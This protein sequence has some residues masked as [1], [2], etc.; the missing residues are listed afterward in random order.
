MQITVQDNLALKV[1]D[2]DVKKLNLIIKNVKF[3][4]S[5]SL[6]ALLKTAG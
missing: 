3:C 1:K 2:Q 6:F 5:V 4:F